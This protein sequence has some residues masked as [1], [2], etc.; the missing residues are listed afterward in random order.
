MKKVFY[1]IFPFFFLILFFAGCKKRVIEEAPDLGYDYFPTEVGKFVEYDVDSTAYIQLPTIDTIIK[2]F[3]IKVK[4]DSI[5]LDNQ[6]RNTM[7]VVRYKKNYD[8]VIPYS[9]MTYVI[10]DIWAANATK[11]TAEFVEENVR[12]I[13]LTFPVKADKKWNG[14]V[15]NTIGDWQYKYVNMDVPLTLGALS[16]EKTL[17]VSQLYFPSVISYQNYTEKYARGVGMIYKEIIDIKSQLSPSIPIFDRIQEGV[18][19]KMTIVNYGQE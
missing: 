13:K 11:T 2:K 6:G 15:Q 12:Y 5:F 10:Q 3:R 7:R 14:N 19:Y 16:F 4:I 9:A 8:A 1:S 17:E 18:I